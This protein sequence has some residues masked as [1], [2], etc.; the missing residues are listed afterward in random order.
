[1]KTYVILWFHETYTPFHPSIYSP[2]QMTRY[3]LSKLLDI[4]YPNYSIS[5]I[6]PTYTECIFQNPPVFDPDNNEYT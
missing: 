1:M 4:I 6:Y 2:I 3:H 5:N